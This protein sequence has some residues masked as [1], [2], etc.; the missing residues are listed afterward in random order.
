M[1]VTG[2]GCR[3]KLGFFSL[4]KFGL[5]KD[6]LA[7]SGGGEYAKNPSMYILWSMWLCKPRFMVGHHGVV[8]LKPIR[9]VFLPPQLLY[10]I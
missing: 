6:L 3:S 10:M 7:P 9:G 2:G 4:T 1:T 8:M 5:V